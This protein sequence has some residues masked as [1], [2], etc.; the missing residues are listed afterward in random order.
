MKKSIEVD[1]FKSGDEI[2][3]AG[4]VL[5][6]GEA[7]R[8]VEWDTDWENNERGRFRDGLVPVFILAYPGT[9]FWWFHPCQ[10]RHV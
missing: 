9:A 7:G 4:G 5:P 1:G 8:V 3:T 6:F 2:R 10:L